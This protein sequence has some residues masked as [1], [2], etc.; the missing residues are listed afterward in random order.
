MIVEAVPPPA[1]SAIP[2]ER[3]RALTKLNNL[4]KIYRGGT[5]AL[6]D[7]DLTV[8]DGEFISILGPSG[9]G[10]S[11]L[12]RI[13]AGLEEASQGEIRLGD[14]VVT[15]LPVLLLFVVLQRYYIRG[16]MAGSVKG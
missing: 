11:T 9:C 6:S 1:R 4:S 10:K 7:V 12:L 13:T 16:L 15:V 5:L 8:G 14:A 3:R 2:N